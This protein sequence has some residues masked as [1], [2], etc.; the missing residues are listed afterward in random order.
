VLVLYVA[1]NFGFVFFVA[2]LTAL[3]LGEEI[4]FSEHLALMT[5]IC[6]MASLLVIA[7]KYVRIHHETPDWRRNRYSSLEDAAVYREHHCKS[8]DNR[9]K[10]NMNSTVQEEDMPFVDKE[11]SDPCSQPSCVR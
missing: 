4:W 7:A 6:V 3:A 11:A 8:H 9:A 5:S 10:K 2:G 1:M